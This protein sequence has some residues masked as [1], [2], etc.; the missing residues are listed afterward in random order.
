MQSTLTTVGN[1]AWQVATL[2]DY[3]GDGRTDIFW[4]NSGTGANEIWRSGN[5]ATKQ[6]VATVNSAGWT[7][8][9]G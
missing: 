7:V 3:D 2:A 6:A 8:I 9:K 4:R 1:Q 5:S